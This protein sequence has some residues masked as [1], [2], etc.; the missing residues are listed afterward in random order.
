VSKL[1]KPAKVDADTKFM[2]ASNTK[3]MTTLML[4]KLVDE[5]KLTWDSTATSLLPQFKLGDAETTSKVLVKHLIC[6]CTGMPRQDM[7]WLFEY[8]NLTPQG[9]LATL[10]T[11]Q[12]TSKFGELFQYS[13]PLAAAAGFIGGHVAFPKLELGKAYDEAM[14]TRV[15]A[16]LGMTSTTFDYKKAESGNAASAHAPDIDG[17]PALATHAINYSIIPLRPAGAAWSTVR[18]MLKYVQMELDEGKLPNGKQYVSREALLARRAPQVAVGEGQTYGM[19]LM[20]DTKYGVTV[21]HH[22]GDMI[23]FHSDMIWLPEHNVGAVILTNADPGW[24]IRSLF[25]RKLLEVLF[26]GKPEADADITAAAKTW[27]DSLA[28]NRKLMTVPADAEESAKLAAAYSNES[29][30]EIK[31]SRAGQATVFDFGEWK[32]EVASRKN[33]DGSIS[34][35][36]TAPGISDMELVVGSASG[37]RTLVIRDPQHEY[38]FTEK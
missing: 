14:R 38:V 20:V 17:K 11:M 26:D 24:L 30:G 36:T 27:F 10:G 22:G 19:G 31:V 37:K 12:P 33:P 4:A 23:G 35:L 32:S 16:P 18:D 8:K 3:A 7:E 6:A 25:R 28:A 1:G 15:F 2:V 34:F 9:A 13:N 29:L 5:K 21:V